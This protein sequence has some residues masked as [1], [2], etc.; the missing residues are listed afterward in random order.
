MKSQPVDQEVRD[1]IINQTGQSHFVTAGAGAGKSTSIVERII[2]L[3][4]DPNSQKRIRM[5]ELVAVTFTEKAAAELRHKLREKLTK[6]IQDLEPG[7]QAHQDATAGLAEVDNAAVGTIHSFALRLLR[8]FPLEAGLP[9]GFSVMDA[10]EA[11]KSF[12]QVCQ[13]ILAEIF[14]PNN[15][16]KIEKLSDVQIG[17]SELMKFV[18]E[19]GSN[20]FKFRNCDFQ[21]LGPESDELE[22]IIRELAK[23]AHDR[24]GDALENRRKSGLV[25][26]DDLLILAHDLVSGDSQV[27]REVRATLETKYK[28]YVVDE[29]QDTD[30]VQWQ[31][32]LSLVCPA[33]RQDEG[34]RPG[35]L[36]VVGDPKQSIYK[37]RGADIRNFEL[38]KSHASE[39]WGADSQQHLVANFRSQPQIVD[40]VDS[41]YKNRSPVLGVEFESM[42][43]E[44]PATEDQ[45]VFILD[46]GDFKFIHHTNPDYDAHHA[47][48]VLEPAERRA[49]AAVIQSV[50]GKKYI[51]VQTNDGENRRLVKYSDIALLLPA[52]TSVEEQIQLFEDLNIPLKSTD[53]T[54][55][56]SR[57]A[58]K[59]LISALRVIAGS[60]N[61]KDLWWTLKSPLFGADDKKMLEFKNLGNFWP[62]PISTLNADKL[63]GDDSLVSSAL[64]LLLYFYETKR[65][66][67]PSELLELLYERTTLHQS[68]DQ[69]NSGVFEHSCIR[70]LILHAKQWESSGGS[71]LL[72]YIDWIDQ[73]QDEAV[74]ENL[75][76]PDTKDVDAITIS[77]MHSAKGLEYEVVILGGMKH[78]VDIKS[79]L[80]MC[81]L[82]PDGSFE[83]QFYI[84]SGKS[85]TKP[86][87]YSRIYYDYCLDKEKELVEQEIHRLLYV[88][89]TRAKSYLYYSVFHQGLNKDGEYSG[90][91][92]SSYIRARVL[93]SIKQ[94]KAFPLTKESLQHSPVT[95]SYIKKPPVS[96]ESSAKIQIISD[97]IAISKT[98][99]IHKPSDGESK[100]EFYSDALEQAAAYGTAFH[101][102]MEDL[103]YRNFD[104]TWSRLQA[105]ITQRASEF[106]V[107]DRIADLS[108]DLQAALAS[109]LV[110]R[111]RNS[112]WV[113]AEQ[114][115][116]GFVGENYTTGIA[117]LYFEDV[118]FGGLVVVDYKTNATLPS[119]VIEKY[120]KQLNDYALL[121]ENATD[122]KVV[123]RFLLHVQGGTVT[124]KEV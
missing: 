21:K 43:A 30:P 97:A 116:T 89:A 7:S 54:V 115:L 51:T 61:G 5:S 39:S 90:N 121:L 45:G 2:T 37:F 28:F 92:W 3:I 112:H 35:K 83:Y 80:P 44:I 62:L 69:L 57:P 20:H 70:M 102:L 33:D 95:F 103:S 87:V 12:R 91:P 114:A 9:L 96:L 66:S 119:E 59:S 26:F 86:E 78:G 10:G 85:K 40:F 67:Q 18:Q 49:V 107:L 46:P 110:G 84:A 117:D 22:P 74:R 27:A 8:Q 101:A 42:H 72:D 106:Q 111:A 123:K 105:R 120:K 124:E 64:S 23:I 58:V 31:M 63:K 98:S 11:K 88:A 15:A 55:V 104:A 71:G 24:F 81:A 19:I 94:R 99:K 25:N 65:T 14:V 48:E 53:A 47:K 113:K 93:E 122:K 73:M 36:V 1:R 60:V 109:D 41:L 32:I 52:R 4:C 79:R 34:P 68:L 50:V 29:F 76:S 13:E 77:T 16:D 108:R 17:L 118:G 38:V 82:G 75:P 100:I 6:R 56:Y